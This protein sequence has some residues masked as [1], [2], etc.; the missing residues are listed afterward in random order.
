[1]RVKRGAKTK[2]VLLVLFILWLVVVAV[3]YFSRHSVAVLDP[4]GPVAHQERNLIFL[5]LGLCAIVVIPVFG[6]TIGIALR[7][8]EGNKKRTKYQPDWDGNRWIEGTWWA[9][10]LAIITVLGVVAWN[11]TYSLDPYKALAASAPPLRVQVVSLD[12]KWLFIYPQQNVASVN[13]LQLPVNRPVEFSITSDTVMNSFWIPNLGSQIY[14][15]PGMNTQLNLLA[16]KTGNF[17]GRSANISGSGFASMQ[18]TTAVSS[19]AGFNG[20]VKTAKAAGRPL[21]NSS[22]AVLTA[23][24]QNDSPKFYSSAAP[25]LYNQLIANYTGPLGMGMGGH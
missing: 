14:S 5:V 4:A 1:M 8:R 24:S 21:T 3:G 10:P 17:P 2:L 23:P 11:S 25:G 22:Y 18:F 15:M 12:W 16:S 20:W 9:V 13:W 7:Y 19:Q 6:L